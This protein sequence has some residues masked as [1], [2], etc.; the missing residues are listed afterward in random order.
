M[1]MSTN[2]SFIQPDGSR[3]KGEDSWRNV[4]ENMTWCQFQHRCLAYTSITVIGG[5]AVAAQFAPFLPPPVKLAAG[6]AGAAVV[7]Q[8]TLGIFTLI[9][10]VPIHLAS[11]HQIGSITVL[12]LSLWTTFELSI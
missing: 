11:L 5:L 9:N 10:Y 2:R 7:G 1:G 3:P 6:C 4:F 8:A 12:G